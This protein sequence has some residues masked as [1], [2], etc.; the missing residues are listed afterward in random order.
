MVWLNRTIG[1]LLLG[2]GAQWNLQGEGCY[3]L[4][5]GEREKKKCNGPVLHG[6]SEPYAQPESP[7]LR[8][9]GL[10]ARRPALGAPGFG[11][12][13]G[14]DLC[15]QMVRFIE[16]EGYGVL[17]SYIATEFKVKGRSQP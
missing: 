4:P 15:F 2:A 6:L 16:S 10:D 7:G 14:P 13:V 12:A 5:L 8:G 17:D 11:T 3:P 1:R 9:L